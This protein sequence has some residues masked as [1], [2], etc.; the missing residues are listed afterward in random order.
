MGL[1]AMESRVHIPALQAC[2][3]CHVMPKCC[4]CRA[5]VKVPKGEF[6]AC[7]R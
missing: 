5:F 1:Q 7:L 4:W 2:V 6:G 3:Y